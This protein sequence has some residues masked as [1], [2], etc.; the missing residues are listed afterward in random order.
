V[1]DY[2]HKQVCSGEMTLAEARRAITTDWA[3][4]WRKIGGGTGDDDDDQE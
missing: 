4:V 3:S 2:L 1:E